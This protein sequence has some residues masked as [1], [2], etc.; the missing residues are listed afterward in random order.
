MASDQKI[1]EAADTI[2]KIA[3]LIGVAA[4]VFSFGYNYYLCTQG[5]W[6]VVF[7]FPVFLLAFF[8]FGASLGLSDKVF[9]TFR[10][11]DVWSGPVHKRVFRLSLYLIGYF[12]EVSFGVVAI[13]AF[14][15]AGNV[16]NCVS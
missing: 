15:A 3:A 7:A 13:Y 5:M 4:A 2:L 1:V 6:Q 11:L 16:P 14:L 12:A 9:G 8:V 10:D